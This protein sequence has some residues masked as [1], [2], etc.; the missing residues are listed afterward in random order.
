[1]T[2]DFPI[3]SVFPRKIVLSTPPP[4][5]PIGGGAAPQFGPGGR[6]RHCLVFTRDDGPDDLPCGGGPRL[7]PYKNS[8]LVIRICGLSGNSRRRSRRPVRGGQGTT[9]AIRKR[10]LAQGSAQPIEKAQ[11]G[12]GNPRIFLAKIWPGFRE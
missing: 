3:C 4:T 8:F 1:M 11:F 7:G 5:C 10:I 9:G 6:E 12:E 2:P